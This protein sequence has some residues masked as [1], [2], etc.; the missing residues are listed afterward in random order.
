MVR[1]EVMKHHAQILILIGAIVLTACVPSLH[2]L[3]TAEDLVYDDSLIGAWI[4]VGADETW[5]FSNAGKGEYKL[6]QIAD[7][8][9][10]GEFSARLVRVGPETFLDMAPVK[11]GFLQDHFLAT[12]TFVH[13]TKK[14]DKVYVSVLEPKWIKEA[15]GQ[16]PDQMRHE[17]I[18]GEVVLTASPKEMQAFLLSN[19]RTR[20]AFTE[21]LELTRKQ[22]RSQQK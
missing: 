19:V 4:D 9:G 6:I 11:S 16:K 13:F 18:N 5:V 22:R 17:T 14:G 15:L 1:R 8:G 3:Y 20:G 7:D 10:M 21:P 12:H 2:P